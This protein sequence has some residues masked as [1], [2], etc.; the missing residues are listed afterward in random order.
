MTYLIVCVFY[1]IVKFVIDWIDYRYDIAKLHS[2][3]E[4]STEGV[5]FIIRA[6]VRSKAMTKV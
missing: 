4:K 2:E 1:F 6:S 3:K 5:S